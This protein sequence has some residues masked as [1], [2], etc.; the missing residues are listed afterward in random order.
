MATERIGGGVGVD[1]RDL[2]AFVRATKKASPTAA[3]GLRLMLRGAG[4]VVAEEAR[5]IASQ[6]SA[7]IPP[8]IK[9]RTYLAT[10]SVSAGKDVPLAAL[11][12]LGNRGGNQD[13]PTFR[14]PV[15]GN[16]NVFVEQQRYPF[17]RPAAQAKEAELQ[18][19]VMK[20]ADAVA[21][22]LTNRFEV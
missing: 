8:T 20:V 13:S 11:Y 14:H 19:A 6:H 21:D 9:A 15:Y 2:R 3:R 1:T 5:H 7:S 16:R 18:E 22:V 12:E 17:L 10:V 4:E